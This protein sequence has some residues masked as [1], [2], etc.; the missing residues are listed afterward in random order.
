MALSIDTLK[1]NADGLIPAIAQD[2]LTGEVKMMAWMNRESLAETIK[3]GKAVFWSRSRQKLWLKGESSGHFLE[4]VSLQADCDRDTILLQTEPLGPSCH[5]G[6]DNCFFE[7]IEGAQGLG[8]PARPFLDRLER[9][10]DSRKASDGEKSYT[11]SLFNKGA[12]K[13]GEKIREEADELAEAI[14]HES[15]ERVSSEAADELFHLLVGLSSRDVPLR[16]VLKTLFQ[17]FGIGGHVE[18]A[19]RQ[20]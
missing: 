17:R 5:T 16:S 19:A 10:I 9:V 11:S 6:A 14:A 8:E 12:E 7:D 3:T 1:Y 2:H 18:K 13:I 4:V 15:D 20:K